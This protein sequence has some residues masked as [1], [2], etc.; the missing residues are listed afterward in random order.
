MG[1]PVWRLPTIEMMT[2]NEELYE[3]VLELRDLLV[4]ACE[5]V[6]AGRDADYRKLREELLASRVAAHLPR[7]IKRLHTLPEFWPY[8]K[9]ISPAWAPRRRH[10]REA[11]QE[12]LDRLGGGADSP[13][14]SDATVFNAGDLNE[15]RAEWQKAAERRRTDPTG[16][17]TSARTLLETVCKHILDE[18]GEVYSPSAD[19]PQLYH[20][21]AKE[22]KIAPSDHTEQVFKEILGGANAVVN[23]LGSLRNRLGDSH[24]VGRAAVRPLPRHAQLAVNLAGAVAVFLVETHTEKPEAGE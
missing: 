1:H 23:G 3:R 4:A 5:G 11:F 13:G 16:A 14:D 15:V 19:L 8:I 21:V 17:I 6:P 22:L 18:R 2:A 7:F 20:A 9:E 24:G 10:V 12:A